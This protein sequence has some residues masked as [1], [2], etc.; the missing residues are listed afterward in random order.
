MRQAFF[1]IF[2]VAAH[3][4][5]GQGTTIE[6]I[7]NTYLQN[8]KE[9][10]GNSVIISDDFAI[11]WSCIPHFYHT[12]FYCY[13]YSFGNLLAL[14]LFQRYKKE[15]SS[16]VP[17]YLS[18]LEAGG[19]KKPEKLL[20]EYGFD[21]GSQKFWQEGFDYVQNQVKALSALN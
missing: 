12:P 10:F 19:A 17:S 6:K 1:T 18:I 15:G 13:A 16:F 11:E 14:S 3:Q 9:Q 2:E 7:S 21:I 8:L 4:Q 20:A 5:I